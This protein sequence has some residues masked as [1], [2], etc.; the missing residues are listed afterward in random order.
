MSTSVR[1]PCGT[2]AAKRCWRSDRLALPAPPV[3]REPF[4]GGAS[5]LLASPRPARGLQR[6]RRQRGKLLPR[7]AR[8]A[9]RLRAGGGPPPLRPGGG[10]AGVRR[11]ERRPGRPPGRSGA[12]PALLR[13]QLANPPRGT[14]PGAPGLAV[15][16][17]CGPTSWGTTV[18]GQFARLEHLPAIHGPGSRRC[19]WSTTTRCRSSPASTAGGRCSTSIRPM[20]PP[21]GTDRWAK[22]AYAVELNDSGP[23]SARGGLARGGGPGGAVR[24][25]RATVPG[26]LRRPGVG[27]RGARGQGAVCC[28]AHRGAVALAPHRTGAAQL[29]LPAAEDAFDLPHANQSRCHHLPRPARVP[30]RRGAR[31]LRRQHGR[32]QLGLEGADLLCLLLDP[33]DVGRRRAR[34]CSAPSPRPAAPAGCRLR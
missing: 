32:H 6:R 25:R 7:A 18:C 26:A 31:C 3:L 21:R 12:G 17:V 22:D 24:V 2:S 16:E 14:L 5:V 11:G 29:R 10:V 13:P 23:P 20:C 8:P 9:G 30:H 33:P 15:R 19:S 27:A 28:D 34:R 4:G 1:V